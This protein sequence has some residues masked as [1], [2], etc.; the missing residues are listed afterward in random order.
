MQFIGADSKKEQ[1][2][3][4]WGK[5]LISSCDGYEIVFTEGE[6][7]KV[8]K[9]GNVISVTYANDSQLY[10]SLLLAAELITDGEDRE[11][12]ECEQFER[13]GVM[14][15]MSRAGVMTIDAVKEYIEYMIQ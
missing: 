3:R 9:K 12:V 5:I 11:V 1:L 6:L 2:S 14:L 8:S 4:L 10:R 7:F 15:D 13:K